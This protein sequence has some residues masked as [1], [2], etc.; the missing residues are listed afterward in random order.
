MNRQSLNHFMQFQELTDKQ[1]E[2]ISKHLPKPAR[3]GRPRYDD[4][5]VL[6]GIIYVLITGCRW[7]E[8]P[9]KYGDDSTA[10]RR[11]NRWQQNGIW[12]NILSDAIKLAHKQGKLNLQKISVDSTSIPA[13]KE[14][15]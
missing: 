15:T 5:N 7:S 2:M 8:M 1:W 4:R 6:N 12:K 13:K 9:K 10:N 11:L 14:V 3:T